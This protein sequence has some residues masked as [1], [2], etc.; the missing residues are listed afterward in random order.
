MADGK[1]T[2]ELSVD[3]KN[4]ASIGHLTAGRQ[5]R[6]PAHGG[7]EFSKFSNNLTFRITPT[8]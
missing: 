2:I 3:S 8:H 6:G 7:T 4:A 5:R 1:I